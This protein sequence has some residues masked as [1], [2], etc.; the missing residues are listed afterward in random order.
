MGILIPASG[1]PL[2]RMQVRALYLSLDGTWHHIAVI[3]AGTLGLTETRHGAADRWDW[4][5]TAR[6]IPAAQHQHER[7]QVLANSLTPEQRSE[8]WTTSD[9][10]AAKLRSMLRK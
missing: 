10:R 4:S 2:D 7:L 6:D 5:Q 8:L 1:D 9:P 3:H